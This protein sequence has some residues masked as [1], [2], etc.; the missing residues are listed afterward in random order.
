MKLVGQQKIKKT[1]DGFFNQ[2]FHPVIPIEAYGFS[3]DITQKFDAIMDTGFNGFLQLPLVYAL[4]VG[5]ILRSTASFTLADGSVQHTIL[6]LGTIRLNKEEQ[7][8]LISIS[9]GN[10]VLIGME[11]LKK[12]NKT[13][14]L[15][16]QKNI[17]RLE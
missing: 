11:F 16:C 17:I 10:D 2:N 3:K 9:K 8:G 12:F 1:M 4:K 15:N 13:L 7:S 5:L 14:H 6:C